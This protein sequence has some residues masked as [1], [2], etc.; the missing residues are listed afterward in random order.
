MDENQ[1]YQVSTL[2]ALAMGYTRSVITAE[3]LLQYG[4]TGLGTYKD[5]DGEM[6][7]VDGK[8][9]RANVNGVVEKVP[10]DTGI[11]FCSVTFLRKERCEMIPS[12]LDIDGLKSWL[13]VKI[14]EKFGLNSMHMVRI[15]GYF[16]EIYARSE[17][18]YRSQHISLKEI[19]GRTQK[20][21]IFRKLKG[22]LICVYFPDYM[23]GINASGWHFHFVSEGRTLGGHVFQMKMREG[24]SII[25]KIQN[26]QIQLPTEPA[27]D[28]YSLKNA[29][30]AEIRQVEQGR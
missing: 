20:D 25:D 23:D 8:C 17:E 18:P 24:K 28:T 13:D 4:D 10:L 6:I 11:S 9:Y 14:E 22:T 12:P 27:F 7:L 26:L 29:S 15:D 16:E 21:F 3:E 2:Q 5:V 1:M 19:L 30:K